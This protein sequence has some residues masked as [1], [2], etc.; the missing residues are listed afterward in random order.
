MVSILA[1]VVV[2][3]PLT[4]GELW[5]LCGMDGFV[6]VVGRGA[7][8]GWQLWLF[9]SVL[10]EVCN[11]VLHIGRCGV[12]HSGAWPGRRALMAGALMGPLACLAFCALWVSGVG[13]LPSP[14][15][16][17]GFG[18]G[19][20]LHRWQ[21]PTASVSFPHWLHWALPR[22]FGLTLPQTADAPRIPPKHWWEGHAVV[23]VC[24][25][26]DGLQ[27]GEGLSRQ[28]QTFTIVRQARAG[29]FGGFC[30]PCAPGPSSGT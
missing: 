20:G 3:Y 29:T 18:S 7:A 5:S 10:L 26:A 21:A 19:R 2:P 30:V 12:V 27:G 25:R 22:L 8:V 16:G 24:P 14:L 1:F 13:G 23:R 11:G 15:G 17:V 28:G 6:Q 4:L 9:G